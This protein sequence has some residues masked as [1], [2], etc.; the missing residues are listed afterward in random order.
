MKTKHYTSKEEGYPY[1]S[2]KFTQ[3][4]WT[5]WKMPIDNPIM[6]TFLALM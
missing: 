6:F 1:K 2:T 5:K 3:I 4:L